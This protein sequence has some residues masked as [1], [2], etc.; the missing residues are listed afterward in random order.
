MS[1]GET[2]GLDPAG[3][4]RR[5]FDE[6]FSRA[7]LD[8]A[9]EGTL[10]FL[11]LRAGG[12]ACAVRLAEVRGLE[13]GRRIVP[14]PSSAPELAGLSG[15][16]GKVVAVF[17]LARLL[18]NPG[19]AQACRWLILCGESAELGLT[20]EELHGAFDAARED[21]QN[22]APGAAGEPV[23]N[24]VRHGAA[25]LPVIELASIAARLLGQ[26]EPQTRT[27]GPGAEEP[28]SGPG[29]TG[30]TTETLR[31]RNGIERGADRP[32]AAARAKER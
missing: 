2:S 22:G 31:S 5:E 30:A 1:D 18:G 26:P 29:P 6:S 27:R 11:A 8:T 28:G 32:D 25:V 7:R 4:L 15:V 9:S 24:L 19:P 20:F 21:L 23:P 12:A 16:R 13:S 17:S 14:V 10:T 3:A